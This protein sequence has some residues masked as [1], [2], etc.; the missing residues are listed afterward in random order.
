M[1]KSAPIKL[2][3]TSATRTK[4]RPRTAPNK[5]PRLWSKLLKIDLWI[6]PENNGVKIA[7]TANVK[8]N[9][10]AKAAM[11]DS[12]QRDPTISLIIGISLIR[13]STPFKLEM[14]GQE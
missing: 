11:I 7:T 14:R 3:T 9:T 6:S 5:K 10:A 8:A 4:I 2:Y 1:S 13:G 12:S